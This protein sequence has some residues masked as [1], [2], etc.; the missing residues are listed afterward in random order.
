MQTNKQNHTKQVSKYVLQ[1]SWSSVR[2]QSV[3]D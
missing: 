3:L 2:E 1:T